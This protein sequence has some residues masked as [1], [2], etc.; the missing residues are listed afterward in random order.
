MFYKQ[1]YNSPLGQLTLVADE[2]ALLGAW[3]VGQKYDLRGFEKAELCEEETLILKAAKKWLDAYFSGE[4]PAPFSMLA[5]KGTDFQYQVWE[6]LLTI[7][8]GEKRTYG[9]IGAEISCKS[10]QAV[11]GAVGKNPIS[12]FI[13]CHRIVGRDG[14]LTGYAGGLERKTWLLAHEKGENDVHIL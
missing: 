5:P 11:G 7:P 2:K 8:A 12:I 13:P 4:N 1:Y 3:F 6:Y 10:G 14:S 9:Q